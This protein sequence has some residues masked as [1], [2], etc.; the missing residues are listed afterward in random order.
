MKQAKLIVRASPL[1]ADGPFRHCRVA[2]SRA[3]GSAHEGELAALVRGRLCVVALISLVPLV[4]F[5]G[6]NL[7]ESN[8]PPGRDPIGLAL[9]FGVT[10]LHAGLALL[11][12][13]P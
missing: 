10:V 7:L 12:W 11:V 4:I 13:S 2:G 1:A 6:R 9:H 3:R 8:S 5:L